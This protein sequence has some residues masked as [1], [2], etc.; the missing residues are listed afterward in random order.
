MNG[1][2]RENQA[3]SRLIARSVAGDKDAFGALVQ[4]YQR[5][6]C[7]V[8]YRMTGRPE[9]AED[10]AQEAFVRAWL[11]LANFRGESQFRT[12]LGRIVTN[13][14]ID[15][16]RANKVDLALD[17][18]LPARGEPLPAQA[19]RSEVEETVRRAVLALPEESRAA[20]ILRE[21]EGLSYK[22]IAGALDIPIGTVMSRLNYARTRLR[23]M[24][25]E[26]LNH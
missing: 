5:F 18:R 1:P 24:L 4:R 8:V 9:L 7:S 15:Y 19:M 2:A 6:A 26:S 11:H 3:E 13:A 22:E 12:W 17:E 23:E 10:L 25:G 20:L 21:Y 16:L 14:T